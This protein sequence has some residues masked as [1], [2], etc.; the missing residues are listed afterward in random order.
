LFVA[1]GAG[2]DAVAA[3]VGAGYQLR[4][5][6]TVEDGPRRVVLE[7]LGV[8]YDSSELELR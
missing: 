6:G 3:G 7:P 4:V 5:A 1:A 8:T 2:A